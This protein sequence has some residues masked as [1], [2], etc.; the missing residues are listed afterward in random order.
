M[1][2]ILIAFLVGCT[3]GFGIGYTV[4]DWKSLSAAAA[5]PS[6]TRV[7]FPEEAIAYG[8]TE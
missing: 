7:S 3:L 6:S 2:D 5:M 8:I 1:P 4:R